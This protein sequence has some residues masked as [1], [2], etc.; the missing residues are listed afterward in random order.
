VAAEVVALRLKVV[1]KTVSLRSRMEVVVE[2]PVEVLVVL[3][4]ALLAVLVVV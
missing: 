3:L 1:M 4:L 2:A